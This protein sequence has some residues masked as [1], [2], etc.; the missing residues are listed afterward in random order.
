MYVLTIEIVTENAATPTRS[1]IT[2]DLPG[3][4]TDAEAAVVARGIR[5]AFRDAYDSRVRLVSFQQVGL[6]R[7]VDLTPP[8]PPA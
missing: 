8:A 7:D 4:G 3:G 5:R 2:F 6:A 1:E